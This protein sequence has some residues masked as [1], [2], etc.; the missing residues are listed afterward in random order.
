MQYEPIN[1]SMRG[2]SV[3]YHPQ[4]TNF[5]P[6][7]QR[8]NWIVGRQVAECAFCATALPLADSAIVRNQIAGVASMRPAARTMPRAA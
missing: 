1:P 5:C 8:S 3:V 6:G 4:A 7:C 2:F